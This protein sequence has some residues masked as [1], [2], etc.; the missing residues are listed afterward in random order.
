MA[1]RDLSTFNTVTRQVADTSQNTIV[2][3]VT[4]LGQKA[5]A[6]SQEAKINE[7]LSKAQIDL[8]KLDMDYRINAQGDPF[9][10]EMSTKYQ[11]DRKAIME[12]YGAD[13]SPIFKQEWITNTNRLK[14]Q[15]DLANQAWGYKQTQVNTVQSINES[16]KNNMDTAAS[17]GRMYASDETGDIETFLNYAPS[18]VSLT[19]FATKNL[20]EVSAQEMLNTYD[21]D[22]LKSFLSG[23]AEKNPVRALQ[24]ME[25]DVIKEGVGDSETFNDFKNAVENRALKFQEVAI[26]QEVLGT[27]KKEATVFR[28]G[29]PMSYAEIQQVTSDMSPAARE[30]FMKANGFADEV[31]KSK[32]GSGSGDAVTIGGQTIKMD[33][34]GKE[35]FKAGIID[36]LNRMSKMDNIDTDSIRALQDQIF[37]GM[38]SKAITR[39][40]GTELIAQLVEPTLEGKEENIEDF[41]SGNWNPF[42]EDVGFPA[43]EEYYEDN[44]QIEGDEDELGEVSRALNATNKSN[45]Y[46]YY[47][48]ALQTEAAKQVSPANPQGIRI[49]DITKLPRKQRREIYTRAKDTAVQ[50]FRNY[51]VPLKLKSD[52][53]TVAIQRLIENP[54][55][56]ADFDKIFGNGAANRIL[57]R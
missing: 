3:G 10:K 38:S 42:S 49:G 1:N 43:I 25:S 4:S 55:K 37:T 21:E 56:A 5:I 19:E 26:Q 30:Y 44:I 7:N 48:E 11:Q 53:P 52:I 47:F 24:L 23:V 51:N 27:L 2:Q 12:G 6:Q 20:G 39:K 9:N 41:S 33:N 32:K 22:Y 18:R 8:N 57:G 13:I 45:L 54:H 35:I 36:N 46:D 16:I 34:T 14:T 15:S 28:T 40:E 17:N 50:S 31:K 29:E